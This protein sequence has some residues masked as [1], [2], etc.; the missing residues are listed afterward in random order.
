MEGNVKCEGTD[1]VCRGSVE[2]RKGCDQWGHS[3]D[4]GSS[5]RWGDVGCFVLY[6]AAPSSNMWNKCLFSTMMR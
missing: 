3:A 1:G 5:N 4:P 2:E 6:P